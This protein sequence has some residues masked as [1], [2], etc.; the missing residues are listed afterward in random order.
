MLFR[1]VPDSFGLLAEPPTV[2]VAVHDWVPRKLAAISAHRTQMG[3]THPFSTLNPDEARRLL[4]VEYFRRAA[5]PGR[6]DQFL[7]Q[8][9]TSTS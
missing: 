4:G 6:A 5:V 2:E 8:L 7:E 3:H 9:C 1:S